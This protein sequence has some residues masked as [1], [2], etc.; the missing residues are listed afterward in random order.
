MYVG[1]DYT[2]EIDNWIQSSD[3]IQCVCMRMGTFV[4]MYV[5]MCMRC[6]LYFPGSLVI[7]LRPIIKKL[8]LDT[9]HHHY[10]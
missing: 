7:I 5:R 8:F 6:I 4:G 10:E 3:G 2:A 1:R 9:S